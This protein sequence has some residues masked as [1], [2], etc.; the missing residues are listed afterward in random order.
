M[1]PNANLNVFT[2]YARNFRCLFLRA[3]QLLFITFARKSAGRKSPLLVQCLE[4]KCQM[5][6]N[7]AY[8][9]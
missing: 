2:V 1:K 6:L 7:K 3:R 8:C 4:L 9:V 5:R